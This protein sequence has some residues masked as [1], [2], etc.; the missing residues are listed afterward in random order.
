MALAVL[1]VTLSVVVLR[2]QLS[3]ALVVRGDELLYQSRDER[4]LQFYQRALVFDPNNAAAA[5]RYV[6]VSMM[7]H[8]R[9]G[10]ERA[11]ETASKYLAKHASDV[12]LLMDRALCER[13]L[14]RDGAA[15][16]DFVRAGLASR[17][18]RAMVFAGYAALRQ[19]KRTR[20][21]HWWHVALTL[22]SDYVPAERA[23]RLR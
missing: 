13:A 7:G 19:G 12:T 21:R 20:A 6:F 1:A 4:A 8:R 14:A 22:I 3:A 9:D 15:E 16:E 5:D 10:L 23:L 11:V 2:S 17:D 18:A